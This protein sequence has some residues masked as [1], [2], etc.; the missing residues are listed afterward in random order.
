MESAPNTTTAPGSCG[1]NPHFTLYYQNTNEV[2]TKR[3][4]DITY[5]HLI[6]KNNPLE[7]I[8]PAHIASYDYNLTK[9]V[10]SLGF[11]PSN[12]KI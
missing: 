6:Q 7:N 2:D 1:I 4:I 12:K 9:F 3:I 10:S 5:N 11:I 8:L